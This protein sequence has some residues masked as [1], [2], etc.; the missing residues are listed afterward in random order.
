MYSIVDAFHQGALVASRSDLATLQV[1]GP[2]RARWLQGIVTNDLSNLD[3]D[4]GIYTLLLDKKGKILADATVVVEGEALLLA[5]PSSVAPTIHAHLDRY[6]VMED[7]EV[8]ADD[9]PARWI[10]I[11]GPA[12]DRGL[13]AARDADVPLV[14]SMVSFAGVGGALLRVPEHSV[15][16]VVEA[17]TR[18][19]ATVAVDVD[20]LDSIRPVVG[21]PGFPADFDQDCYPQEVGLDD[22]AISFNKGCYLGQEIVV[23]MRSRGHPARTLLRL[24]AACSQGCDVWPAGE[25]VVSS[26][27]EP[28]GATTAAVR[29]GSEI[30]AFALVKWSAAKI[31]AEVV[32]RG[33]AARTAPAWGKLPGLDP[34]RI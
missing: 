3:A 12:A 2:D 32:V 16:R 27:G 6:L 20:T 8:R 14:G 21:W 33:V 17:C 5:V 24:V 28:I 13:A 23:K 30:V 31:G 7:A 10:Q 18:L 34:H 11:V 4:C 9:Q 25:P 26:A 22:R 1:V 15:S 29:F 19:P